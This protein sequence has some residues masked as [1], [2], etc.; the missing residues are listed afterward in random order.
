[1][2]TPRKAREIAS[3]AKVRAF[4]TNLESAVVA[5]ILC[6]IGGDIGL[7]MRHKIEC[8]SD[9]DVEESFYFMKWL[10]STVY[11]AIVEIAEDIVVAS[12][13]T[14]ANHSYKNQWHISACSIKK[15]R[16]ETK[17]RR[18]ALS[19]EGKKYIKRYNMK[20]DG[21]TTIHFI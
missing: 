19:E 4:D 20:K 1:M 16:I 18:W 14:D 5:N 8:F 21:V 7:I 10:P 12:F 11:S 9:L 6:N 15:K 2:V 17:V 13:V 3:L